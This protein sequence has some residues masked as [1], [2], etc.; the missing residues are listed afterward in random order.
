MIKA[1]VEGRNAAM[2]DLIEWSLSMWL[3]SARWKGERERR[4][5]NRKPGWCWN[6]ATKMR[7]QSILS[8]GCYSSKHCP[9][10]PPAIVLQQKDGITCM[11]LSNVMNPSYI[12]PPPVLFLSCCAPDLWR[13]LQW[14]IS[15]IRADWGV[16][17]MNNMPTLYGKHATPP[18]PCISHWHVAWDPTYSTIWCQLIQWTQSQMTRL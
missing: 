13:P 15:L 1:F 12:P 5:T 14:P 10:W 7:P 2:T 4:E 6:V 9:S 11:A 3:A 16:P 17:S 18:P 8:F